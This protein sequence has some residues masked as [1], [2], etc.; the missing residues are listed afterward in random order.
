MKLR[1]FKSWTKAVL[2][3]HKK[4]RRSGCVSYTLKI[5][6]PMNK[7]GVEVRKWNIDFAFT[8]ISEMKHQLLEDVC[9]CADGE[10]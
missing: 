3:P 7:S 8:D 10:S 6:N 5:I 1:M 2:R 4:K 9:A